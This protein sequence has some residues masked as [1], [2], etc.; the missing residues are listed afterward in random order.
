MQHFAIPIQRTDISAFVK[1]ACFSY[2]KEKIVDQ[3]KS[4]APR[5]VCISNLREIGA[6]QNK[7]GNMFMTYVMQNCENKLEYISDILEIIF[8]QMRL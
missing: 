6:N 3:D 8:M 7:Q 4:W 1:Q 2:F 5:K